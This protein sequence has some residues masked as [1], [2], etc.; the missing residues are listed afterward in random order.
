MSEI[1]LTLCNFIGM[2]RENIVHAATVDIHVFAQM[3]HA[4]AGAFN[5]PAGI[6]QSPGAFPF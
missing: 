4:D 3:L 6:S 1:G 2:V 5:V